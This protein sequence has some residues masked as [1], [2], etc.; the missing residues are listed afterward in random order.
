MGDNNENKSLPKEIYNRFG[1]LVYEEDFY[2]A[3]Y[4][5]PQLHWEHFIE[6]LEW[7]ECMARKALEKD[8]ER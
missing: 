2:S 7:N 3:E 6:D 5:D 1:C 8:L 4:Y